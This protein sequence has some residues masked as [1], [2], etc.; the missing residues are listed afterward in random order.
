MMFLA[1]AEYTSFAIHGFILISTTEEIVFSSPMRYSFAFQCQGL[2]VNASRGCFNGYLV[3][4]CRLTY[5]TRRQQ[6]F[7]IIVKKRWKTSEEME[8]GCCWNGTGYT[9]MMYIM[10]WLILIKVQSTSGRFLE[11]LLSTLIL[12]EGEQ[13][14]CLHK[15]VSSAVLLSNFCAI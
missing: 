9:I 7:V 1:M 11:D 2:F 12:V 13:A 6:L 8:R 4:S 14:G 15:Q 3:S 5:H 10:I